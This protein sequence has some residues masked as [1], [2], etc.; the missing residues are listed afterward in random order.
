[1]IRLQVQ[2]AEIRLMAEPVNHIENLCKTNG[3]NKE[4]AQL[5]FTSGSEGIGKKIWVRRI[6][7]KEKE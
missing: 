3:E 1:M 7:K 6:L 5:S 4:M 2:W